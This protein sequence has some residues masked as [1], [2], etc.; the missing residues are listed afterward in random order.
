MWSREHQT[1]GNSSVV[2]GVHIKSECLFLKW[3]GNR[4]PKK[5]SLNIFFLNSLSYLVFDLYSLYYNVN[6]YNYI[7]VT[8]RVQ[9]LVCVFVSWIFLL[10]LLF[11]N[12]YWFTWGCKES[13]KRFPTQFSLNDYIL[14]NYSTIPKPGMWHW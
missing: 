8:G 13:T 9:A 7:C 12:N 11:W 4:N 2:M 5:I 14:H 1:L 10:L 3:V 6:Y